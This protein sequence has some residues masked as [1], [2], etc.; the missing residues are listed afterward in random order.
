MPQ[1]SSPGPSNVAASHVGPERSTS[2]FTGA[3][4]ASLPDN[5]E[6][7]ERNGLEIASAALGRPEKVGEVPFYAGKQM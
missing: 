7:E 6:D 2:R 1:I 3:E 5:P 4:E